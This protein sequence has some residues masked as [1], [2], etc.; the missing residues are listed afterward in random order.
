M[1]EQGDPPRL[2]E[3]EPTSELGRAFGAAA[4]DVPSDAQL[5]RLAERLGPVLG[6]TAPAA[7]PSLG[8]KL[9]A[10]AGAAAI[11]AGGVFIARRHTPAPMPSVASRPSAVIASSPASPPSVE[12]PAST[13]AAPTQATAS[14]PTASAAPALAAVPSAARPSA[15]SEATLLERARRAL[16]SDPATALALTT[17]DAALHPH[18]VLTQ[19]REVI[20]IEALRR[21]NRGAEAD[22]RAAAFGKAFPGSAHQRAVD[23]SGVK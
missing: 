1:S 16:V 14:A 13:A 15:P 23:E 5:A 10:L 3:V 20:A 11:I 2:V 19:E 6:P 22:R 12:L 18:G 8:A 21:L 7:G 9:G 17:Q 4:R